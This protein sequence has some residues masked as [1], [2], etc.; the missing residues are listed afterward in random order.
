MIDDGLGFQLVPWSRDLE[1]KLG[2]HVAG[3]AGTTAAVSN[4][5]SAG[6]AISAS[7][8][9][10]KD[11]AMSATKN[12]LGQILVVTLIV[13]A[14]TGAPRNMSP[15]AARVSGAARNTPGSSSRGVSVHY[16]PAFFWWWY[17]YDAYA[18]GIFTEGAFHR[19]VP[20]GFIAIAVAIGM[21]VCM[22]ARPRISR[23]TVRRDGPRRR[24]W[25]RRGCSAL[26]AWC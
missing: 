7:D 13:L 24:R 19:R 17:F 26:T 1:R 14:T 6:S 11:P 3:V 20:G 9:S 23:P 15:L 25:P 2:Q 21:S 5:R 4:G 12:P 8:I 22:P 18:P 10:R 16:P